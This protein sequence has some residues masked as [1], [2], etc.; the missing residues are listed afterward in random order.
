[1]STLRMSAFI[2]WILCSVL[3]AWLVGRAVQRAPFMGLSEAAREFLV[4]F[5]RRVRSHHPD[6][7][8]RSRL[9]GE[10]G[11]VLAVD[12]QEIAV[13]LQA[14][15][16]HLAAFPSLFDETVDRFVFEV[17]NHLARVD[18][19]P[20]DLV[21]DRILPQIRTA[22][23]VDGHSPVFGDARIVSKAILDDLRIC[24]VLDEPGSMVFVTEAHL[25]H[26]GRGVEDID[27]LALANLRS[28]AAGAGGLPVPSGKEPAILATRDGYD[29][30][31]LLLA[32]GGVEAGGRDDLLFAIPDRDALWVGSP[33][34]DLH[35]L[36]GRV[37]REHDRSEH[38]VSAGVFRVTAA[39]LERVSEPAPPP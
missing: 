29:A 36:M 24:Y 15:A 31:R 19:A 8:V 37:R 12:G 10:L 30:A 34:G 6:V 4:R 16:A 2:P 39:G 32:C 38:P 23:W 28:R 9:E 1:M 13:P 14:L 35:E 33:E 5:S 27:N 26:W 7:E 18:D 20:F 22:S 3:G 21:F 11:V 25:K 17:R